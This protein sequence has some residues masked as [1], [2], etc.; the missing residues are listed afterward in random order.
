MKVFATMALMGAQVSGA[1]DHLYK[2]MS[3]NQL[4]EPK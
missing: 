2:L 4:D 3:L 1:S